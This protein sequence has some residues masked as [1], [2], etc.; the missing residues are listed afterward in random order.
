[1]SIM[2]LGSGMSTWVGPAIAGIFIPLVGVAGVM[3]IFAFTYVIS[4][5]I[6]YRLRIPGVWP[7]R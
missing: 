1:M 3:W 2:N 7:L 5:I 4:A 6:S